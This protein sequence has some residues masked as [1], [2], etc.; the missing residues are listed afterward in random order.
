MRKYVAHE[1]HV[2][3]TYFKNLVPMM[4]AFGMGIIPQICSMSQHCESIK[5]KKVNFQIF[6]I[7]FT[8]YSI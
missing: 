8:L 7:C 3:I 4:D 1:I 2:T 5:E 6:N